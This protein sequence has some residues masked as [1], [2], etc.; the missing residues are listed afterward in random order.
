MAGQVCFLF[1]NVSFLITVGLYAY[2][3]VKLNFIFNMTS[4]NN[5]IVFEH[6]TYL[7]RKNSGDCE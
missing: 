6:I 3:V 4:G 7:L 2:L 5:K 1:M